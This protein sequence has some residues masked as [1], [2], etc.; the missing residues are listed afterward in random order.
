MGRRHLTALSQCPTAH[1]VG[2]TDRNAD[3]RWSSDVPVFADVDEL[4]GVRPEAIIVATPACSHRSVV[5][6]CLAA[7]MNVLVEKPLATSGKDAL[8]LV[9]AARR[10]NRLL[11]VGHVERFSPVMRDIRVAMND[12]GPRAISTIRVGPWP[13]H[14]R[15]VG[16]LLDLATHDADLVR[17]LTGREY[18]HVD[19]V[20]LARADDGRETHSRVHAVLDDGT[21]VT[22]EVSWLAER[23]IRRWKVAGE[24]GS[25]A[26]FDLSVGTRVAAQDEAFLGACIGRGPTDR[27]ASVAD[28]AAAVAIALAGAADPAL[29]ARAGWL[30]SQGAAAVG[31]S[32]A[33]GGRCEEPR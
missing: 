21:R 9:D 27:L 16:V 1:V 3:A 24:R 13:A 26:G 20:V 32:V 2:V 10:A 33:P 17:W 6:R 4:L 7:G 31:V 19:V 29:R 23:P 15:D 28:G 22:H 25:V 18:A 14:I 11:A 8:A 12:A 5:E 30:P